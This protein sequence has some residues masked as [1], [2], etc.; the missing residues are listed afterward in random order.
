M[1]GDVALEALADIIDPAVEIM[2]DNEINLALKNGNNLFAVKKALKKHKKA[3]TEILAV[4]DG[5]DPETYKPKIVTLPAKLLEIFNDP[6]V[7]ELFQS[8][9]QNIEASSGSAMEN[10]E[11]DEQ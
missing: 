1:S 11:A 9:G 10:I 8:Q 5:E 3:V 2:S 4:L 7:I 6:Y